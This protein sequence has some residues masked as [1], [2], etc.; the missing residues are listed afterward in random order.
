MSMRHIIRPWNMSIVALRRF[1]CN[2]GHENNLQLAPGMFL[3]LSICRDFFAEMGTTAKRLLLSCALPASVLWG[4]PSSAQDATVIREKDQAGS[5]ETQKA[6][7][8]VDFSA[9]QLVYDQVGDI[10]TAAGDVR[11]FRDGQ[12]LRADTVTWNR[13]TGI[14]EAKGNII[15]ATPEGN[16]VYGDFVELTDTLR[17]GVIDNLLIVLDD[18]SRLAAEKGERNGDISTLDRA[19][20]TACAVINDEGCPRTPPWKITAVRVTHDAKA[21]KVRYEGAKLVVFGVPVVPLP[22]LTHS[23]SNRAQTGLLVPDVK[24]STSNGVGLTIPYYIRL[25]SNR[26][27]TITTNI[28]TQSL[29]MIEG[30]Y[31]ALTSEGAYQISAYGSYSERI[32]VSSTNAVASEKEF[33][34]YFDANGRFQLDPNWGISAS[35]RRATDRTF[36]RRYDL[37]RD[38]RL[39]SVIKAE[40]IDADSYL[41]IAGWSTQTLR[42]NDIQGQQPIAL[43]AIDY[44][45]RSSG[46]LERDVITLRGNTLGLI[47]TEGEDMA[48]AFASAQYDVR[49]ITK[50]GHD[51]QFTG[52]ARVDAYQVWDILENPTPIYRGEAGFH[53][54]AIALLAVDMKWPLA[55]SLFGGYQTLTPRLQIVATPPIKNIEFPNE[56]SRAFD[57]EDGNIFSLN[58]FPGNDRFEDGTRL[59]AGFDYA[60]YRGP[61]AVQAM[62][63]QSFRFSRKPSLFLDGTGLTDRA[64]D[65]VGRTVVRYKDVIMFTHRFRLDKDNLAVRRN[66]IDLTVGSRSTYL[67]AGYLRLNRDIP[68]IEDL[69]DREELR[70]GARS[71]IGP[72]WSVFGSATIDLTDAAE[73]LTNYSDGFMPLRHQLGIAYEDDCFQFA[74]TWRRDYQSTGDAERGNTFQLRVSLKNLGR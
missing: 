22:G 35:I 68:T 72:Y 41:S 38:D 26:D 67:T 66:E 64:S 2:S 34:G 13:R 40:R 49:Q 16:R 51:V 59:T 61:V 7:Q 28:Y 44:Y 21:H 12:R 36:L 60:F 48:R 30:R 11:M 62:I 70:V 20:Y 73:D 46:P 5:S 63:G 65:V 14:V 27:L 1:R 50:W 52:L 19:S 69:R 15:L 31:R 56:D 24:V 23:D 55:G 54:R 39:R 6:S 18:G 71:A 47:R 33:R 8:F 32:P 25:A 74:F 17:N 37:S 42:V 3:F 10:V 43:P 53:T 29:P 4:S 58:R 45:H 57:L 9:D